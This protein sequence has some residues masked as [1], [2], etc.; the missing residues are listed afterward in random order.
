MNSYPEVDPEKNPEGGGGGPD[1]YPIIPG[2]PDDIA[3][4]CLLRV[5]YPYQTLAQSVSSSWR[6][7]IRGPSFLLA[8]RSLSFSLPYLFVFAFHKPTARIR[9]QALDPR[10]GSWFVLP[11][12]PAPKASSPPSFAFASDPSRGKLF[13]LGG[14]RTDSESPLDGVVMYQASI[15]RWSPLAPMRTP[16]AFFAAGYA[17][18]RIV[19]AGGCGAGLSTSI[20]AVECYDVESDSWSP[21]AGMRPGLVK[22]DSAVVGDRLYLTEGWTWPFTFT[23]RGFVYDPYEDAWKEMSLGMREGW[24]GIAVVL[25]DRLFVVSE[26]GDHR[27]KVYCPEGDMWRYVN[28]DRFPC[29]TLKKPFAVSGG[30]GGV[31]YVAASGLH[32][33]IG[34]VSEV[35]DGDFMVAWEVIAAPKA[36]HDFSPC[37][38][39]LLYA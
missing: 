11:P 26:H 4:L 20:S 8:R 14:A 6:R 12:M 35:G 3:E 17:G 15:N 10:S 30:E 33:G 1:P 29:E 28:G 34:R 37:N 5:P 24:T 38:A 25:G 23:P 9:W 2:L 27:L 39:Q 16:R 19:A 31:I 32:V 21:T 22:Y 7:V 13:V 36:F 18:G